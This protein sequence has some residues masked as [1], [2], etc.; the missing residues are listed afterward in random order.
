[1]KIFLFNY[2]S[3]Y[4]VWGM[5]LRTRNTYSLWFIIFV[6]K[7]AL[8][9]RFQ[10]TSNHDE[11]YY[12]LIHN[13]KK[14]KECVL[15]SKPSN[16][17]FMLIALLHLMSSCRRWAKQILFPYKIIS[18]YFDFMQYYILIVFLTWNKTYLFLTHSFKTWI[19]CKPI[20]VKR[21]LVQFLIQNDRNINV[22]SITK[23]CIHLVNVFQT[24]I[25]LVW[26]VLG[27]WKNEDLESIIF[28]RKSF[29]SLNVWIWMTSLPQHSK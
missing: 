15:G 9:H 27:K 4:I 25:M 29:N 7:K 23:K 21:Q 5:F 18:F 11:S 14:Y 19:L 24:E 1:M 20:K 28:I 12:I 8:L 3:A 26:V 10:S 22:K 13:F 2:S 17:F 16:H 6:K